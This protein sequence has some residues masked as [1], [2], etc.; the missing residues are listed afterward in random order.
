MLS[1]YENK[2][3][4]KTRLFNLFR[5]PFRNAEIEKLFIS[6]MRNKSS[7]LR[8]LIPSCYL[9]PAGSLR[10]C[11]RWN[12]INFS[13]DLSNY[14]DHEIYFF[15]PP[16][17]FNSIVGDLPE[18]PII[19]DIGA[20]IGQAALFFARNSSNATIHSFEPHPK[21]FERAKKNLA[22]N[23]SLADHIHLHPLGLGTIQEKSHIVQVDK[24]NIGKNRINVRGEKSDYYSSEEILLTSMDSFMKEKGLS[25]LDLIKLDV[26]GFE[27][28]VLTGGEETI[29]KYKPLIIIEICDANLKDNNSSARELVG[30]LENLGYAVS[31]VTNNQT[32]HSYSNE[33]TDCYIDAICT[34][35]K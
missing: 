19:L 26:E 16:D 27:Y 22:L 14:N 17:H 34:P 1:L 8:H 11:T 9:Y 25:K 21:T 13:L 35:A 32:L 3:G 30:F 20:N 28:A 18:S 33:L 5:L 2:I 10:N 7:F 23:S 24:H 15:S 6:K 29:G 31:N 4:L 12:G